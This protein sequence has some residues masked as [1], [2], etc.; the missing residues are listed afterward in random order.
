M[1]FLSLGANVDGVALRGWVA[2]VDAH[3]DLLVVSVDVTVPEHERFGAEFLDD[4]DA[5]VESAG[6]DDLQVLG[7]DPEHDLA[8]GGGHL[9][10]ENPDEVF[11]EGDALVAERDGVQGS[12]RGSP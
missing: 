4:V 6:V 9:V 2:P 8:T 1:G 10:P 5:D 11:A 12:S 3:H 7:P